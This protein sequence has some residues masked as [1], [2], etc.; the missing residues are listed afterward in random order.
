M[1][2]IIEWRVRR[3]QWFVKEFEERLRRRYKY[4]EFVHEET[5]TL[6]T[7]LWDEWHELKADLS[8]SEDV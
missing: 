6:F 4:G 5:A 8:R 1:R 7:D 3:Y 2:I